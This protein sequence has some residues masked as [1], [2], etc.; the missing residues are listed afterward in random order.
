MNVNLPK[1]RS[2]AG[3]SPVEATA[4]IAG[5]V[6][7]LIPGDEN[8]PSASSVGVQGLLAVRLFEDAGEDCLAQVVEALVE[9]GGPMAGL[10]A[11]ERVALVTRFSEQQPKLFER[12]RAATVLAYYEHPFVVDAIR[13]TG[14]PYSLRPHVTGY[15]MKPFDP[16]QDTPRHGR[17]FYLNTDA[18][19][20]LDI[21]DLKLDDIR[22]ERWGLDR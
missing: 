6:D 11:E 3:Q 5:L 22:T 20:R 2:A 19:R 1:G 10:G 17:G 12:V 18:V 8:W 21:S 15:P 14:R 7:V 16:A 9:A 13:A 4:L